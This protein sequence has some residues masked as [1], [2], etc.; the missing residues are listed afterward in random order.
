MPTRLK[1]S[2][3]FVLMSLIFV[4]FSIA[5]RHHDPFHEIHKFQ[6]NFRQIDPNFRYLAAKKISTPLEKFRSA[7]R[8]NPVEA[9]KIFQ[10]ATSGLMPPR[11]LRLFISSLED[12]LHAGACSAL[13]SNTSTLVHFAGDLLLQCDSRSVEEWEEMIAK[14]L[15]ILK[16]I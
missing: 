12:L 15:W 2:M 11:C 8:R 13:L 6:E 3:I 1:N 7:I 14:N 9:L 10:S 16:R 5:S 4:K